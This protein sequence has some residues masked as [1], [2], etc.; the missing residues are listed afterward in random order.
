MSLVVTSRRAPPPPA[1]TTAVAPLR[2][3]TWPALGTQCEVQY[4]ATSDAQ[5]AAFEQ[6]A[7]AW[8]TAFETKYSRFRPD[9]LVS[10]INAAA[11]VAPVA[12]DPEME[13]L[14]ALCDRLHFMTQGVLDP[15]S[16]PLLRLWDYK[17]ATPRLPSEAAI[18]ATRQLVG[19]KKI[20]RTPGHVFLPQ[21]GM[22]LDFGGFG[23]EWAVDIVSAIAREH[24]IA[25][26]L[27]DFG[28]DLRAVGLPP[29]RPAWHVGLE[30]PQSP[31]TAKGSLA[32]TLGQG[33]ASSGDYLRRVVIDGVRYG[34][35]VDPRT[36]RPVAN[37]CLQVTVIAPT[38]LQAGVLSTAAFVLG[39]SAGVELIQAQP[40]AEGLIITEHARAQTRGF[41]NYAVS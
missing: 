17:A 31:G 18:Q 29:G 15:T 11:G 16:L 24:G 20:Q 10:R 14:L 40:N 34:H 32:L 22:A 26:A 4:A 13:Q 5:A 19:W 38:C 3:L 41:W 12:I 28:H 1:A 33:V 25:A 36:G 7:V 21:P 23:K 35:I 2:R 37:G 39:A 9:S 27:V 6:A 8:V 30:D